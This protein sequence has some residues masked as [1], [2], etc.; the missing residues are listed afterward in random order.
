VEIQ[1]RAY[2][3]TN[4]IYYGDNNKKTY[5]ASKAFGMHFRHWKFTEMNRP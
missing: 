4:N 1:G 5:S 3:V 2:D